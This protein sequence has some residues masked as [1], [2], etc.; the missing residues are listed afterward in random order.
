LN[1]KE[2]VNKIFEDIQEKPVDDM[3][4]PCANLELK[5]DED[6]RT[7]F[8]KETDFFVI[9][10]NL[11]SIFSNFDCGPGDVEVSFISSYMKKNANLM[12][13]LP[14]LQQQLL[15]FVFSKQKR[16]SER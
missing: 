1:A 13:P 2:D 11:C 15:D 16:R 14:I 12:K 6:L 9:K 3:N 10:E 5:I 7:E 4:F 8:L